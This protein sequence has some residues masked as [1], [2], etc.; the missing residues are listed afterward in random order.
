MPSLGAEPCDPLTADAELEPG[1]PLAM[2][3]ARD[4]CAEE[5]E[6]VAWLRR[7]RSGRVQLA[8]EASD[9]RGVLESLTPDDM[10]A[11]VPQAQA[12]AAAQPEQFVLPPV[13]SA[14]TLAAELE[15]HLAGRAVAIGP[16]H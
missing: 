12:H 9:Y 7:T 4:T 2:S 11:L 6:R 16:P 10:A 14:D 5:A 8:L 1:G 15:A 3:A 13:R